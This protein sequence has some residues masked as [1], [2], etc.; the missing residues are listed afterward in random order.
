[1]TSP[2]ISRRALILLLAAVGSLLA[3]D[4]SARAAS[5][6]DVLARMDNAAKKLTS[7]SVIVKRVDHYKYSIEESDGA[8]RFKRSG[9]GVSGIMDFTTGPDHTIW[10]LNGGSADE[11]LPKANDV[12]HWDLG[13]F[14]ATGIAMV[15]FLSLGFGSTRDQLMKD[16]V[17][18]LG[19]AE[20]VNEKPATRIVLTPKS[21]ETLTIVTTIEL[22]IPDGEGYAIQQ[23]G[24]KPSK[25]TFL[26]TFSDVRVNPTLPDSAFQ[27][28]VP[29]NV[30]RINMN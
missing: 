8:M 19:G 17:V 4:S 13:K 2:S 27:L 7:Y 16:Y 26:A 24:T 12:R 14:G 30:K 9:S 22:W 5:L 1:V 3:A 18:T 6:E 10:R 11:Y 25:E 29:R 15:Q 23:K 20:T 28:N 21:A